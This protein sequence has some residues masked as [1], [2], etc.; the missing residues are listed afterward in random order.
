[1]P[2]SDATYSILGLSI[3]ENYTVNISFYTI[4]GMKCG[5]VFLPHGSHSGHN[6]SSEYPEHGT[7]AVEDFLRYIK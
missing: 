6:V 2:T 5:I 1:M 3:H 4:T 7:M